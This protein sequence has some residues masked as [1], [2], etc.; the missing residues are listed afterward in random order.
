MGPSLLVPAT[1]GQKAEPNNLNV[2]FGAHCS[3]L[4]TGH[5]PQVDSDVM[6]CAAAESLPVFNSCASLRNNKE[7]KAVTP[8][9]LWVK[10]SGL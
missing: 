1:G 6:C 8:V 9:G 5:V 4:R 7:L 2:L 3:C 10:K